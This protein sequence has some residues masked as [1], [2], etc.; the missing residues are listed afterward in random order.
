MIGGLLLGR[1]SRV[2]SLH[3][4]QPPA[5]RPGDAS[6]K[7][8]DRVAAQL[9]TSARPPA[10]TDAYFDTEAQNPISLL[11]AAACAYEAIT[12]VYTS[13]TRPTWR[14]R[15]RPG[16]AHK[17]RKPGRTREKLWSSANARTHLRRRLS[18][19]VPER[20]RHPT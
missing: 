19:Q 12:A 5:V 11:L 6:K 8:A 2:T 9:V 7:R 3:S 15:R 18:G 4:S 10:P 20:K 17:A 13:L 16:S 1:A 14:S